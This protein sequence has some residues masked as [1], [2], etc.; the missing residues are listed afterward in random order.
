MRRTFSQAHCA[1]LQF[2]PTEDCFSAMF[3]TNK[4]L[5]QKV[6][7]SMATSLYFIERS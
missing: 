5:E 4:T 3:N 7:A 1:S 2:I 6:N